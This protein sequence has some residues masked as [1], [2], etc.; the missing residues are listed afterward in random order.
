MRTK[1]FLFTALLLSGFAFTGCNDDDDTYT[2]DE[3][4]QKAFTNKYPNASRVKWEKEYGFYVVDFY[5]D[6]FDR[7]AWINTQGEWV[8]TESDILYNDLPPKV[9]SAFK[10]SEYKDWKIDDVDMFERVDM[11]TVYVIEV[12]QR[13]QETDLHYTED[14]TLFKIVNDSNNNNDHH[15]TSIP[16]ILKTYINTHYQGAV[17]LEIDIENGI[18]EIDILHEGKSKEVHFNAQN[19]WLSTSWDVREIEVLK[20]VMD[21]INLKYQGYRI[22][23]IEYEE[24]PNGNVY[25]FELEKQNNPDIY[26]T[27]DMEGKVVEESNVK[28]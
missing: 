1:N 19:E 27:V 22:D 5:F 26:V 24:R 10:E 23:D 18:T 4:I 15:P 16:E 6:G 17:I 13:K 9:Q 2:P 20:V 21:A 11:E 28:K 14:G 25:V 12:E 8:M 7:E 3:N